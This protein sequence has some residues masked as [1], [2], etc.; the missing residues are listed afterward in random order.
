MEW[1]HK[2]LRFNLKTEYL[3]ALVLVSARVP[4]TNSCIRIRPFS[5][6][7]TTEEKALDLL[8]EQICLEFRWLPK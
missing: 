2:G 5:A 4:S 1:E 7:G 8:K 6:L 3:G